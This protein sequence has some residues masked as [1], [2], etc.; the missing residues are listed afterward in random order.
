MDLQQ[1]RFVMASQVAAMVVV[2][3]TF[4]SSKLKTHRVDVKEICYGPR[5]DTEDHRQKKL[6]FTSLVMLSVWQ[7]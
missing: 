2:M 1:Q 3:V 6:S 4:I 7:C 5:L